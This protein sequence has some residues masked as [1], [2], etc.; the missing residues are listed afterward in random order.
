M[1]RQGLPSRKAEGKHRLISRRRCSFEQL[2]SR[3][4]LSVS[5]L[6]D[7]ANVFATPAAS[8]YTPAQITSAYLANNLNVI[9]NLKNSITGDGTGQTIA[10]V[11]AYNDPRIQ[12]DLQTFSRQFNLYYSANTLKVVSQTGSTTKL[13]GTDANWG[14]EIAL[15]VEWAH[16]IAPKAT[17]LLVEANSASL[18]NLLTAVRYAANYPGVSVVSM[19]WGSNEFRGETSY[20]GYFTTPAG[21]NGVTFIASSGDSGVTSWPAV[22][23]NVLSVGGTTLTVTAF[24]TYGGETAWSHSGGGISRYEPLPSYQKM[25]GISATGRVTPDVS[26]DA[27]PSSGFLV[28]DSLPIG[29]SSGWFAVGGTSAVR[30]NG[31]P[32]SLLP[33]RREW[34]ADW[35]ALT[36][37]DAMLYTLYMTDTTSDFH[38]VTSGRN[39]N[40]YS[41]TVGY[42][43]V[44]GL[45][46]PIISALVNDLAVAAA[47]STTTSI[48]R[49]T[50][51][52]TSA[53]RMIGF[54]YW[55]SSRFDI[56][57]SAGDMGNDSADAISAA[58]QEPAT[59]S[60]SSA[61]VRLPIADADLPTMGYKRLARGDEAAAIGLSTCLDGPE[62]LAQ[63]SQQTD[64]YRH[65]IRDFDLATVDG[66]QEAVDAWFADLGNSDVAA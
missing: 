30:R 21:H 14:L 3:Q 10:I 17:I 1:A 39:T 48:R 8:Y 33:T 62:S 7:L 64:R 2:E 25:L 61:T 9:T 40:G 18:S 27:N 47:T 22:A 66:V 56:I 13:P 36:S 54:G 37:T 45:G 53:V 35:A 34:R 11:D 51:S 38:D 28:Y 44:T 12:S 20:D 29:R 42:D 24:G 63:L 57:A 55:A 65:V 6:A 59:V 32:F 19:S 4:L 31:P 52:N 26:Y 49:I 60:A 46:S 15:D 41:A 58:Y 16:A 23:S 50:I 43:G 5:G